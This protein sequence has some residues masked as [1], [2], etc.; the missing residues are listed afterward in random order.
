[1]NPKLQLSTALSM[2]L[3]W[4]LSSAFSVHYPPEIEALL[5]GL[6]VVGA[7]FLISWAAETAEMDIP[8]SF[9]LAIVALLAILPEYA[10]DAY[11]AWMAGKVGGDYVHY[12]TANMTGANRLLIGVG[13]SFVAI[14]AIYRLRKEL[15][16]NELELDDSLN[17][18]IV[19]LLAATLYSFKI[20]L[21]G[22]ISVLDS[23]FLVSLY[24]LYIFT[25]I[26]SEKEEFEVVGV[27]CYL[28]SFR[29]ERRRTAVL[30]M[31]LYAA[32]VILMSVEAFA[33]GLIGTAK[34]L[35]ID[36]FIVVQW[37][38]PLASEAPEFIVAM[39]LANRLRVSASIN[40]LIS[41]KVNQ[42]SLLVGTIALIYSIS[43]FELKSLPLDDRQKEEFFLT[44]AQSLFGLA[45]IMDK[46]INVF[47]ASALLFLFLIQLIFPSVLM[48][49]IISFLYIAI[50]IPIMLRKS[51]DVKK[52][53]DYV[54]KVAKKSKRD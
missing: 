47:E 14:T 46:R 42:W 22:E 29:K 50:A 11:F 37:I 38:A 18:E 28:C 31:F 24:A 35:G 6:A 2:T 10:V 36:E 13:W 9:S 45:I 4:M 17:L 26:K 5:A 15:K 16:K 7:A 44:A 30:M 32:F 12:A 51:G 19:F 27:P 49:Y 52:A 8:R 25:A 33:E 39:Y 40:A 3:P 41:S 23:I 20:P 48:R 21:K 54:S 53:L 1:M 43:L 34:N